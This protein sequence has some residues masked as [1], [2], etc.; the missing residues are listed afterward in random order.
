MISALEAN[1]PKLNNKLGELLHF[2][3]YNVIMF[4]LARCNLE[5]NS[6]L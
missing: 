4:I 1:I 5:E 3:D 6:D 2:K